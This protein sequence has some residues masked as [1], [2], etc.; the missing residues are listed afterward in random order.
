MYIRNVMFRT[1]LFVEIGV[2]AT[3]IKE[4]EDVQRRFALQI[5]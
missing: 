5:L 3:T 4:L 1:R 2:C